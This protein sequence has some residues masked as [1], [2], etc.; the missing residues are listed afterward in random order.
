MQ[1]G[2]NDGNGIWA[3]NVDDEATLTFNRAN[4]Y[5]VPGIISGAGA[6]VQNNTNIVTL[7]LAD[8]YSGGTTV[9][10]GV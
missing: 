1:V 3:G 8:T 2:N 10:H 6:V 7:S 5:T 9:S 4:S